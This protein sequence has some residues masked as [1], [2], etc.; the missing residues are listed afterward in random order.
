MKFTVNGDPMEFDG[1]ETTPIL[2]V[3]RDHLNLTGTKFG[4]GMSLCGACTVLLGDAPIRSCITPIMV[5]K[6]QE[7][8][9][10]EGL[11]D[12]DTLHPVQEAWIEHVVP[13]CGYCQSGQILAAAALLKANPEPTDEEIDAAMSGNICRCGTYPRI[14]TAIQTA[15]KAIAESP[16]EG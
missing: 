7:L 6:D 11:A 15:A 14:R 9:T 3:L 10:I 1:D 2:W 4:C 16:T 5:A 12:G 13:Q 8:T